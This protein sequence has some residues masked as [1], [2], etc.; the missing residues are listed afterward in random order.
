MLSG[1]GNGV[2]VAPQGAEAADVAASDA[3]WHVVALDTG[4]A[5]DKDSFMARAAEAF[6]LPPWFDGTWEWLD[7]LLRVL[8][9]DDPDGICVVWDGWGSFAEADPDGF[10]NAVEVFQDVCV[11]WSDDDVGGVVLLR[12]QG[13]E[14]DLVRIDAEGA[15]LR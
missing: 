5:V 6:D 8:D 13:P 9:L 3:G 7:Q 11:A 14:T 10:E 15:A 4:T 1:A 2:F 12:G